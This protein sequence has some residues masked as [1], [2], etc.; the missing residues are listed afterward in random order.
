VP[1]LG[2][3]AFN[4]Y[5]FGRHL[6][7]KP[8]HSFAYSHDHSHTLILLV[9]VA[10]LLILIWSLL[11]FNWSHLSES[12]PIE[13]KLQQ[14]FN[15]I[16]NINIDTLLSFPVPHPPLILHLTTPEVIMP[17]LLL[18]STVFV[19]PYPLF[20]PGQISVLVSAKTAYSMPA[21][22]LGKNVQA[23]D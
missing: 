4:T 11:L 9:T 15:L 16:K 18:P 10:P 21:H 12:F 2:N 19:L 7:Y 17:H 3:Q 1:R 22:E 8:L 20:L 5:T 23:S 14:F 13:H 6:R